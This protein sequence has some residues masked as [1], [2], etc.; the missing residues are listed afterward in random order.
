[1]GNKTLSEMTAHINDKIRRANNSDMNEVMFEVSLANTLTGLKNGHVVQTVNRL[2]GSKM[3][4]KHQ[5]HTLHGKK[6]K[7]YYAI[8][9]TEG[10]T[11]IHPA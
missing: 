4:G 1:M 2:I 11:R 3:P 5:V 10:L 9:E 7:E 6:K 8:P